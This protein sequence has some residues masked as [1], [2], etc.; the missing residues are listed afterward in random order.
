MLL[1][2][3]IFNMVKGKRT[4]MLLTHSLFFLARTQIAAHSLSGIYWQWSYGIGAFHLLSSDPNP[5]LSKEVVLSLENRTWGDACKV[6]LAYESCSELKE[7]HRQLLVE[8]RK[9]LYQYYSGLALYSRMSY[10]WSC[11]QLKVGENK[12][13]FAYYIPI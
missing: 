1:W 11:K 10:Q 8:K 4:S 7:E 13:L 6:L 12:L 9:L 3:M 5:E 2:K